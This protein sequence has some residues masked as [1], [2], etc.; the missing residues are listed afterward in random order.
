MFR[1]VDLLVDLESPCSAER[2]AVSYFQ[3]IRRGY[4]NSE[5]RRRLRMGAPSFRV[6][7]IGAEQVASDDQIPQ[8][9]GVKNS[10][11]AGCSTCILVRAAICIWF[12]GIIYNNW[13]V[14][15]GIGSHFSMR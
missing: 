2:F 5:A 14:L 3:Y 6:R 12:S 15:L 1:S 9:F 10:P 13:D 11:E 8:L 7:E 4:E